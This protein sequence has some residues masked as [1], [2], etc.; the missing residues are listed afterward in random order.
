MTNIFDA[1]KNNNLEQL[2]KA[3]NDGADVNKADNEGAT[4]LYV[5]AYKG[6]LE[7]VQHLL[8][9]G[10]DVNKS[11]NGGF[12]PLYIAAQQGYLEVV[13]L[14]L[15]NGAE[16]NKANSNG[17]TP[18]YI[19]AYKGH[20][21]VVQLLLAKEGIKVNKANNYG[22]TPI[23][24]AA[25]EGYS[26]VVQLLLAKEDI[27]VNA[28]SKDGFTPLYIAAQQGYL[29]IVKLLLDNG[30]EI[31]KANSNG[32]TPLYIAA[33]KGRPNIVRLLFDY[34]ADSTVFIDKETTNIF[35]TTYVNS[36]YSFSNDVKK[37]I[38]EISTKQ[39][40]L[41]RDN[42]PK[43]LD[44]QIKRQIQKELAKIQKPEI[45]KLK[46]E[47]KS[48]SDLYNDN[49]RDSFC[50]IITFSSDSSLPS[51][52][53]EDLDQLFED[54]TFKN[55]LFLHYVDSMVYKYPIERKDIFK[56]ATAEYNISNKDV[57]RYDA[58]KKQC[59][60]DNGKKIED[61]IKDMLK[62]KMSAPPREE[63][64]QTLVLAASSSPSLSQLEPGPAARG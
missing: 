48:Y 60:T 61:V 46:K 16:I 42:D 15:D 33:K 30:A 50:H 12:T 44:Y 2:Q 23:Y 6:H 38:K 62:I 25:Q 29:E 53:K 58:Y 9:N 10:A 54:K 11:T 26:E 56:I 55:I 45:E 3:I 31:N 51:L 49:W 7:V 14:L 4:P 24:I 1:I 34:G 17:D 20:L 63:P 5:A 22:F 21:E 57:E 18:L 37:V 52:K 35:G 32:T 28:P 27:K 13:K 8:E 39:A 41:K 43:F 36:F 40:I 47:L 59:K 64:S 19:A